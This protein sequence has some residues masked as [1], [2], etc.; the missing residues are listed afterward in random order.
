MT[1]TSISIENIGPVGDTNSIGA[2]KNAAKLSS[3]FP[4]LYRRYLSI[5]DVAPASRV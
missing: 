5:N 4:F 3:F 2:E 1:L